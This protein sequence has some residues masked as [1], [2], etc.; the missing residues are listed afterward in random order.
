MATL[1]QHKT[2]IFDPTQIPGE[3]RKL[4]EHDVE[5]NKGAL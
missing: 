1:M 5:N 3:H 4:S 2:I